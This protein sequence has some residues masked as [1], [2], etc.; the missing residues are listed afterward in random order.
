MF[1][2]AFIAGVVALACAPAWSHV[3]YTGRDFGP[4][5]GL[6]DASVTIANQA[7]SG[8]FGWADA[9]DAD[10]GDGTADGRTSATFRLA[11]GT[12][13][14]VIGGNVHDA[15]NAGVPGN[16]GNFGLSATLSVSA[17]PEPSSL[18]LAFAGPLSW[19]GWP[20]VATHAEPL[21]RT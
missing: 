13:S 21:I 9:T 11:A 17:V 18:G 16:T 15:Q 4:F 10:W 14:I 19:A 7:I 2:T 6:T 5:T 20:A 12:Y 8:N 1:R 3:S